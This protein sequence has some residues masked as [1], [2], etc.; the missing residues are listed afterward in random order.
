MSTNQPLKTLAEEVEEPKQP[1]AQPLPRLSNHRTSSLSDLERF[2]E[3]ERR[4]SAAE[5]RQRSSSMF[6]YH[7]TTSLRPRGRSICKQPTQHDLLEIQ[8]MDSDSEPFAANDISD[9]G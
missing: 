1:K 7:R 4:R 8:Q 3:G 2:Q 9:T 5:E 6:V